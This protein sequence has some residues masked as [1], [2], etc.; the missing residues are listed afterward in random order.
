MFVHQPMGGESNS[1]KKSINHPVH[2]S[3]HFIHFRNISRILIVVICAPS[4][5]SFARGSTAI[6][7]TPETQR[8]MRSLKQATSISVL[9]APGWIGFLKVSEELWLALAC[10][11][12]CDKS[13]YCQ[14]AHR[15]I[16]CMYNFTRHKIILRLQIMLDNSFCLS[17]LNFEFDLKR[18]CQKYVFFSDLRPMLV[19]N[20]K[21]KMCTQRL[22]DCKKMK[23]KAFYPPPQIHT[24]HPQTSLS[25]SL[26]T[27]CCLTGWWWLCFFPSLFQSMLEQMAWRGSGG[28]CWRVCWGMCQV[29]VCVCVCGFS[30]RA[31][32]LP[33][34]L[35][36]ASSTSPPL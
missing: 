22:S 25:Q 15:S 14:A 3:I 7:F 11:I 4:A 34:A 12:W 26:S 19:Q 1:F 16:Q 24:L 18:Q 36:G 28:M 8:G 21:Q 20:H 13:D 9:T 6:S 32:S 30:S 31:F 23:K 2:S 27:S 17:E 5:F 10:T 33:S 29:R 35:H